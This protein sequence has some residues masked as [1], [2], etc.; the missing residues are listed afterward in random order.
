MWLIE[1]GRFSR[2]AQGNAAPDSSEAGARFLQ[3]VND[4]FE[5]L[6]A[7]ERHRRDLR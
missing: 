3:I 4:L 2:P 5:Y 7:R 6:V 1:D